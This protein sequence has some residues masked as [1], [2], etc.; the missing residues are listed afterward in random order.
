MSVQVKTS[1]LAIAAFVLGILSLFTLGLTAIPAIILGIVGLSAIGRSG[2]RLSGS[3]FAVIGIILPVLSFAAVLLLAI[4]MPALA[5][6]RSLAFRTT[7]GTNLSGIGKAM[8]IYA[9]DYED[10]LPR[11]GGR[12]STWGPVT[13]DAGTR[14]QAYC[15]DAKG[16][17]GTAN[18]SSCFYLLVKYGEVTPKSFICKGD[19]GTSEFK[20]EDIA[21][22]RS[23]LEEIDLWNFGPEAWKHCS[24]SYHMPFGQYFLTT[25]CNP[26]FAVA[27]D[28]NPF[29]KSPA[30]E[31]ADYAGFQPDA[32]GYTGTR[33]TARIGNTIAHQ[34]DGQYVLFL[35][36]HVEFA[37]R[38]WRSVD[39]DNIYL[40]SERTDG[41]GSMR[42]NMPV[43][44][45]VVPASRNDSVLVHD[46]DTLVRG[47]ATRPTRPRR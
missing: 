14:F 45:N 3:A 32:A 15:V 19:K 1:G 17:G 6:T 36:T 24:Y 30:A 28:R 41:T 44:P 42:G 16:N 47:R 29:I 9:N 21:G 20:I 33:T 18:I 39:D 26:G 35:D 38:P 46:P 12:Q 4:L 34:G 25:S 31:A 27:A 22:R 11:A 23:M 13:W 40:I 43:P 7:C 2:G 10:E 5:R 8:M 37:K